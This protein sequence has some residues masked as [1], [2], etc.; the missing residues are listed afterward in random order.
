MKVLAAYHYQKQELV[1]SELIPLPTI[2]LIETHGG[3]ASFPKTC[4]ECKSDELKYFR[5]EER[6]DDEEDLDLIKVYQVFHVICMSCF[7]GG[8]LEKF[9]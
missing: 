6:S 2:E 1:S 5:V 4:P 3:E 7:T 8:P 9:Q